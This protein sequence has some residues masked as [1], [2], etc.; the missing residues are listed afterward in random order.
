MPNVLLE[1]GAL[2][3]PI[4]ASNTGG[5]ADLLSH[6]HNSLLFPPGDEAELRRLLHV[7][8]NS[9]REHFA[10]LGQQ[11]ANDIKTN[12]THKRESLAYLNCFKEIVNKKMLAC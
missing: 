10:A 1:A 6:N 9:P 8:Y 4:I 7:I 11:L 2:D 12:F 5:M 3:I